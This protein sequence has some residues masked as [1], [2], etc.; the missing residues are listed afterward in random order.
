MEAPTPTSSS[1]ESGPAGQASPGLATSSESAPEATERSALHQ[2]LQSSYPQHT[3]NDPEKLRAITH[4]LRLELLDFLRNVGEGTATECA[5]HTGESVASC[6]F[7]LRQLAKYGFIEPAQRRGREKPWKPLATGMHALPDSDVPGSWE[8]VGA[9]A[10]VNIQREMQRVLSN[11]QVLFSDPAEREWV[12]RSVISTSL[13]WLTA[14]ELGEVSIQLAEIFAPFKGRTPDNRPPDSR[15]VRVFS[16]ALPDASA[17][18]LS[19]RPNR[20]ASSPTE[21]APD[22]APKGDSDV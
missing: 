13:G 7:H 2:K 14:E 11:G 8:A 21:P 4:P 15:R 10:A 19:H 1:P 18:T 6:S 16:A 9:L 5:A 20:S 12:G 22:Q 3:V 17:P